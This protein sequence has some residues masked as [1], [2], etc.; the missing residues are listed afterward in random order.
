MVH[1]RKR[2]G[3]IRIC[4]DF[5]NLNSAC[6]KDNFPLPTMEQILQ[7]VAGSELMSFLG[8]FSGYNQILVHLDD[9]LKKTFRTK[10]GTYASQKMHF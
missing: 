6:R 3:D 10:W 5:T 2:N 7:S 8:G 1:V 9:R 4:I